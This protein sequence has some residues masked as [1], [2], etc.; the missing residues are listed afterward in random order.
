MRSVH[1]QDHETACNWLALWRAFVTSTHFI[2]TIGNQQSLARAVAVVHLSIN[3]T[4]LCR[5]FELH[6]PYCLSAAPPAYPPF[7]MNIMA[8]P[9]TS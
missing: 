1:R 4:V 5:H 3:W 7:L 9:G 2:K 8:S 6:A